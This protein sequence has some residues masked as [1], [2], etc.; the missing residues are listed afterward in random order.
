VPKKK[1]FASIRENMATARVVDGKL[2]V[3]ASLKPSKEAMDRIHRLERSS[4]LMHQRLE[5][6]V[7]S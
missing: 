2:L 6:I 3:L 7:L 5:R 4:S 1:A